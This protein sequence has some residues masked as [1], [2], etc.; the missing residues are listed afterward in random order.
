MGKIFWKVGQKRQALSRSATLHKKLRVLTAFIPAGRCDAQRPI[1][2]SRR[3]GGQYQVFHARQLLLI[4]PL[5]PKRSRH[6]SPHFPPCYRTGTS[7][8]GECRCMVWFFGRGNGGKP[9]TREPWT[10]QT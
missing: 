4:E 9:W 3:S 1:S 5:I 2:P 8:V 6:C 7:F 10:R